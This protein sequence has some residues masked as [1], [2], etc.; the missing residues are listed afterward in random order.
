MKALGLSA[1][2]GPH[3][4]HSPELQL[5]RIVRMYVV[6]GQIIRHSGQ[7]V[8]GRYGMACRWERTVTVIANLLLL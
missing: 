4:W 7:V 5:L 1:T 2:R 6:D 8:G 3:L